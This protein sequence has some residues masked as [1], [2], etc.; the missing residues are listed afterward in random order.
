VG[1]FDDLESDDIGMP[2]ASAE[3]HGAETPMQ[4]AL[5]EMEAQPAAPVMGTDPE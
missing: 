3:P 2:E 5:L 1:P 4:R